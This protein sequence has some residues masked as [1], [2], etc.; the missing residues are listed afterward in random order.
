[1]EIGAPVRVPISSKAIIFVQIAADKTIGSLKFSYK[2]VGTAYTWYES[3][4][5]NKDV[6]WFDLFK[7]VLFSVV[8][9]IVICPGCTVFGLVC[10]VCL[11]TEMINLSKRLD[12]WGTRKKVKPHDDKKALKPKPKKEELDRQDTKH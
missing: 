10:G 4:F 11:I 1:M 5:I 9:F 8:T 3:P 12:E 7:W 2:I 6:V